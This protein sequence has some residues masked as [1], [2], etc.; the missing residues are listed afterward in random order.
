[1]RD[2]LR[3]YGGVLAALAVLA[4]VLSVLVIAKGLLYTVVVVLAFGAGLAIIPLWAYGLLDSIPY[5]SA[6]LG[7]LLL[8]VGMAA[9]KTAVLR[10]RANTSYRIAAA[11]PEDYEPAGYW[12]RFALGWLGITYE[13]TR[14]TYGEYVYDQDVSAVADV[15]GSELPGQRAPADID[16]GGHHSYVPTDVDDDSLLVKVGAKLAELRDAGG[17]A[18]ISR[19]EL[20]SLREYAGDS[21]QHEAS[22]MA[23]ATFAFVVL[24]ALLGYV[25]LFM[26]A[27]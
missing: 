14:E 2:L 23:A 3:L 9:M 27:A 7:K 13:R 5:L 6:A 26:G 24:G 11:Q 10:Q 20:E 12:N 18:S 8:T 17:S 15:A 4:L 16:R 21:N 19:Q 25:L 22:T 1:M